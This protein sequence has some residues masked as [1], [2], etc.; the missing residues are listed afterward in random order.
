MQWL[1][2]IVKAWIEAQGYLTTSFVDRGDPAGPDFG[3]GDIIADDTWREL[4]LS[5]IVPANTKAILFL[6]RVKNIDTGVWLYFR[7]AG[8]SNEENT[9]RAV[10]QVSNVW[11]YIDRVCPISDDRKIEYKSSVTTWLFVRIT[12]KGWWL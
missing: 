6:C 9:S 4:D 2:D 5:G 11:R 3:T 1:I 8:N 7:K 12:V 10:T